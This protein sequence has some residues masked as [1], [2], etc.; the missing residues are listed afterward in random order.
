[1]LKMNNHKENIN[2]NTVRHHDKVTRLVKIKK[3]DNTKCYPRCGTTAN[4]VILLVRL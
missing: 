1:M 3:A 2:C 4:F